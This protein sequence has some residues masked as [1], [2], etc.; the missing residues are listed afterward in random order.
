MT[1]WKKYLPLVTRVKDNLL[2]QKELLQIN[3]YM[4]KTVME[5]QEKLQIVVYSERSANDW[6]NPEQTQS[7][8]KLQKHKC[9]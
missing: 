3:K 2:I 4:P 9:K 7:S 8:S 1:H 5:K 6:E